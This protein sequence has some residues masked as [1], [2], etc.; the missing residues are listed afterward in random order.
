[1][2]H[3]PVLAMPAGAYGGCARGGNR[4]ITLTQHGAPIGFLPCLRVLAEGVPAGVVVCLVLR[5][6]A[7]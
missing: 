5:Q 7:P 4:V 6:H 1:M 2:A 3:E